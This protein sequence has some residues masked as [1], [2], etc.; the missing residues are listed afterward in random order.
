M[1][2]WS[3]QNLTRRE[4]LKL[5]AAGVLGASVSGWFN[6]LAARAAEQAATGAKHKSCILL[7]MNGGPAQSHTF[8]LKDGSEYKAIDTAVSGIQISEYL[9][10]VAKV[11][12]SLAILRGMSTGEASHP[13][14]R[15]LMHT[16]Y[17]Q[18]AGG[19]VYP[20]IGSIVASE[21]G[22]PDAELPNFVAVG[23]G[24]FGPGYLGPK[25]A[26]LVVG[27]PARGIENLKPYAELADLDE[28]AGLLDELDQSF[29]GKY[30][31]NPIEAHAKGY[32]RAVQLMHSDRARAFD[33][34]KEKSSVKEAY[35]NSKFGEGCLLARRLVEA[36]VPFVEVA[37]NGWDTHGGANQPVKR[38]SGQIDPGFGALVSDLKERGLLDNTLIIWMGEFGR[39]PGKGTNHFARAWSSVLG[40]AGLKTGQVIGKTDKSGGTVEERPISVVDFMATVCK[41]LGIDSTKQVTSRG[42]RPFRLV[43]KGAKLVEELF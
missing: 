31:A 14:A 8:D 3:K 20:S 34:D 15:Y 35:G 16:G 42:G 41:A 27:D 28:K 22:D 10:N 7:W 18:G 9:P 29:L 6:V 36:G 5:T 11:M 21:L 2:G 40:G 4:A 38:L 17:R 13:R 26:P 25:W 33:I 19:T 43:D 12:D 37:L 39:S 32:Q 23:A 30:Q 1:F 24:S